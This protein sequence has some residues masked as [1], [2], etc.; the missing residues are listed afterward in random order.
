MSDALGR[1]TM[2]VAGSFVCAIASGSLAL[3]RD[4]DWCPHGNS[5]RSRHLGSS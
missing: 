3:V 4:G 5:L 2:L 1:K